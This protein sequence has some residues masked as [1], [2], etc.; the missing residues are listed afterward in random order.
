MLAAYDLLSLVVLACV[1]MCVLSCVAACCYVVAFVNYEIK[2]VLLGRVA[3]VRGVAAYSRQT[4]PWTI[5]RCVGL[6]VGLSSALW[7]NGGSD[8]DAVWRLRSDGSRNEAGIVG[9]GDRS[10]GR[11][12]FGAH[13][14]RDIVTNGDFTA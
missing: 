13:L 11:G 14:G 8:R 4:F 3:L 2:A 7:K 10:T 9:F 1:P 5:C 12:M 6:C